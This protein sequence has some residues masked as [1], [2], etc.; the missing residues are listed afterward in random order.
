MISCTSSQSICGPYHAFVQPEP[1]FIIRSLKC[2]RREIG[3]QDY[4][5][6]LELSI[7]LVNRSA[8][9]PVK[10]GSDA[11]ISN[12]NRADSR[13]LRDLTIS[14]VLMGAVNDLVL[15]FYWDIINKLYDISMKLNISAFKRGV[16]LWGLPHATM[17]AV[18]LVQT[19]TINIIMTWCKHT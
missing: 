9:T 18:C 13:L 15:C 7:P 16:W 11:I 2:L 8:E 1:R 12:S 4:H 17:C 5:L 3:S 6:A 10:F 19:I 14:R